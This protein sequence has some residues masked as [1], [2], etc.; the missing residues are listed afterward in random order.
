[1]LIQLEAKYGVNYKAGMIYFTHNEGAFLAEGIQF[2]LYPDVHE[3]SR[4]WTH[5][6]ICTGENEGYGSEWNGFV[7][8][9]LNDYFKSN[10]QRIC[11]REPKL[12]DQ[13]GVEPLFEVIKN[14]PLH[15]MPY[16]FRMILGFM[17]VYNPIAQKLFPE[18]WDN[19]ILKK[20]KMEGKYVCS[21]SVTHVDN[22]AGYT[23]Q[24]P[25][26]QTPRSLFEADWIKPLKEGLPEKY[27]ELVIDRVLE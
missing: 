27:Q 7:K 20:A 3:V 18:S 1:M 9:N 14:L 26:G 19:W 10:K 6:G 24:S 15:A 23:N 12:L 2:F 17:L 11:F 4:I 13:I 25:D 21:E 5:V 22:L 8:C 16:D